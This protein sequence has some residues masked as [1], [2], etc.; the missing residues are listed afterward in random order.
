[1][2]S[3]PS[4]L[5]ER[6]RL[7]TRARIVRSAFEL[8]TAEGFDAVAVERICEAAAVSRAT[9]F[10]YFSQKD[11]LLIEIGRQRLERVHRFMA[12][13][14]AWDQ[15]PDVDS[16]I[17]LFV[18][19]AQNNEEVAR[20]GRSVFLRAIANPPVYAQMAVLKKTLQGKVTEYLERLAPAKRT[21]G[22]HP[23]ALA[24]NAIGI[25]FW[26]TLEYVLETDP[27]EGKLAET[28]RRRLEALFAP[29]RKTAGGRG[30]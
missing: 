13:Q 21:P 17:D 24:E 14:Q 5:R 8:F 30:R 2:D 29:F 6:N 4:G 16:L 15:K 12:A 22:F 28:M 25:Y 1:M 20:I 18:E 10:N 23:A 7:E 26:S 3:S 11:E 9:F 19:F 27:A